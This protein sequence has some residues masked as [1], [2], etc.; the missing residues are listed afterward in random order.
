MSQAEPNR[1]LTELCERAW[2]L[3]IRHGSK[4]LDSKFNEQRSYRMGPWFLRSENRQLWIFKKGQNLG[5]KIGVFSVD[6]EGC[7]GAL[8]V[9]ECAYALEE[10]RQASILDDLADIG[11]ED[12]DRV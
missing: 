12:N 10:F 9:L 7:L 8:N 11:E 1:P 3:L 4:M 5:E 2:K 6:E